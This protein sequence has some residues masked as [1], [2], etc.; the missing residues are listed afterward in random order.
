MKKVSDLSKLQISEN[1]DSSFK[2]MIYECNSLID[3]FNDLS[4]VDSLQAKS[5]K[6]QILNYK[7]KIE[8]IRKGY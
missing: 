1:D 6:V 3:Q 2:E 7:N 5:L 8:K 4:D